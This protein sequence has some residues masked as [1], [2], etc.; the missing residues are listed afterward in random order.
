LPS[1][2]DP[3][4]AI[5]LASAA[6]LRECACYAPIGE[7]RLPDAELAKEK[8]PGADVYRSDITSPN[9]RRTG[10]DLVMSLDVVCIPG[11]PASLSGLRALSERLAP[12]GFMVLNLPAYSWLYAEHD[13]AVHTTERFDRSTVQQLI[14][15]LG[16][17]PRVV[18]YRGFFVFPAILL[19]RLPSVIKRLLGQLPAVEQAKSDVKESNGAVNALLSVI[20]TMEN[21]LLA[22]GVRFPFGS[23]VFVIAQKPHVS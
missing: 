17:E 12:N 21:G 19:A 6:R 7:P 3:L 9:V 2:F 18:T 15:D 5:D 11:L 1:A 13:V 10:Y 16:L 4:A 23:S 22:R 20:G 8:V 14:A